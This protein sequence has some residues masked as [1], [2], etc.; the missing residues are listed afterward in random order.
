MRQTLLL[1]TRGSLVLALITSLAAAQSGGGPRIGV[2]DFYG[3]RKAKPEA[4]RKALGVKEGD[5]LPR[6]KGDV[7]DALELVPNVVRARLEA[8]C[9]EAGKAILY[10]GIEERG[11]A[12]FDYNAPPTGLTKLPEVIHAE[13]SA[14]LAAVNMAVRAGTTQENLSRGHSLMEDATVRGHQEKFIELAA[15]H[16]GKIREVLKDSVDEEQRAI[17][18]Y[19]IGYATDKKAVVPDLQA[20]LRDPDDTVRNNAM[21]SLGAI[22]VLASR[23]PA[24][25]I[26]VSPVWFVEALNSLVWQDRSTAVMTLLT[27]TEGSDPKPRALLWERSMDALAEMARWKHLPHALP[28]FILLGRAGGVPEAEIQKAWESG[29]RE[30]FIQKRLDAKAG[31]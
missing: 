31:K 4:I 1:L 24:R 19:V 21:R 27:L 13:Y 2:V 11:A 6:S 29:N 8:A 16:L 17:A 3:I 20:A 12:H 23:E 5:L 28:A 22:A 14:F 30:A 10:V 25:H 9:C 18:A 15:E 7:E 26:E